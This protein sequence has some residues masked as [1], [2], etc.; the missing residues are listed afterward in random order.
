MPDKKDADT[1][2]FPSPASVKRAPEALLPVVNVDLGGLS[3]PGKVRSNN[4]DCFLVTRFERNMRMLLSN[5]APGRIP[6]EHVEA[7]YSFLVADGMGGA[8]AG[9][10]ASRTAIEV[11]INLVLQTPDWIMRFDS[12]RAQ[13]LLSRMDQRFQ[14]IKVALVERARV[15]PTLSGMGTTLTVAASLGASLIVAHIGDSRAYLFRGGRLRRLTRDHT[16]AEM[17]VERGAIRP[18]DAAAHPMRHVLTGAITS[19]VGDARAELQQLQLADGD[20]LLLCTDGLTEMVNDASIGEVLQ[21]SSSG[22]DA[23]RSL[24][25]LALKA[26]GVD[27]VTVVVARYN[28]SPADRMT[29]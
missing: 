21:E 28:I 11:L 8:A 22:E 14:Q 6:A 3:H 5:L 19:G 17:L 9:E 29:R 26:G 12:E 18:E 4:E 25:D 15:D 27:N 23:C 7:G 24:V 10:V 2:E 20:Q 16:V 13:E 1:V